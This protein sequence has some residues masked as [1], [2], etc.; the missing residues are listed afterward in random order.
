MNGQTLSTPCI[1]IC[2]IEPATRLCLGC[3]RSIDEISRWGSMSEAE[4]RRIM[5][6]LHRRDAGVSGPEK[7]R[8]SGNY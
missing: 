1:N 4:R 2:V 8:E 5:Q 6:D 7:I 3:L